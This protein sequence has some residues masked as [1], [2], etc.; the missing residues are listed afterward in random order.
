MAEVVSGSRIKAAGRLG[1][2][3]G[4][5]FNVQSYSASPHDDFALRYRKRVF[6]RFVWNRSRFKA[7]GRL[8]QVQGSMF[9]VTRLGHLPST[10]FLVKNRSWLIFCML[11]CFPAI[12]PP[13]NGWK[14]AGCGEV[15][16]LPFLVTPFAWIDYDFNRGVCRQK[17]HCFTSWEYLIAIHHPP[18]WFNY[19][20]NI[21]YL[22]I[23]NLMIMVSARLVHG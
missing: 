1:Q 7:A 2:V 3:Q 17:S 21:F 6:W 14:L 20:H 15:F 8:G 19:C 12:S 13:N 22:L 10:I 16:A 11:G 9:K 23:I 18:F 4:S 5:M